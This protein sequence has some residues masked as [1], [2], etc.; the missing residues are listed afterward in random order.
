MLFSK[1]IIETVVETVRGVGVPLIIDPVMI[2]T[3]GAVLLQ[4]SALRC[5]KEKLLPCAALATPNLAEAEQLLGRTITSEEEL[6]TAARD[7]HA[8]FG[9]AALLKGG[10]LRHS[11]HRATSVDFFFDGQ[12]ELMLEAPFIRGLSTHGTGCTFSA[13]ITAACA[14]GEPLE[15]AIVIGKG[16]ISNAIASSRRSGGHDLLNSFWNG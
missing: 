2:A 14:L 16:F 3:S 13:A 11:Q 10:H 1:S 9:C 7:F 8:R 4:P 12:T 6:R 5:L 15:K